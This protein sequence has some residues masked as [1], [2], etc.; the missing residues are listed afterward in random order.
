MTTGVPVVSSVYF[1]QRVHGVLIRR[2]SPY[3]ALLS[4]A[5][6]LQAL[7]LFFLT[8]TKFSTTVCRTQLPSCDQ[9]YQFRRLCEIWIEQRAQKHQGKIWKPHI[10][11]V[12]CVQLKLHRLRVIS[13]ISK[14]TNLNNSCRKSIP[15]F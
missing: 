7:W 12:I 9:L 15:A 10:I 14:K 5:Y 2:H 4:C 1:C 6:F 13:D 11:S 8:A 3:T